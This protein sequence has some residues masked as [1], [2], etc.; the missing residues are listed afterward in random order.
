[1]VFGGG[2]AG[3]GQQLLQLIDIFAGGAVDDAALARVVAQVLQHKVVLAAGGLD[4]KIQVRAVK[5]RHQHLGVLQPQRAAYILL[6]RPG[7]CGRKG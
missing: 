1:M 3:P 2:K 4:L 5:A 6:H 7:R